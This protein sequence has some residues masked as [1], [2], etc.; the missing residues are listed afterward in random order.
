M[1]LLSNVLALIHLG[2]SQSVIFVEDLG[3][4]ALALFT[5]EHYKT[6][7]KQIEIH[8]HCTDDTFPSIYQ[9]Q[10]SH[11]QPAVPVSWISEEFKDAADKN[12][13]FD[14]CLGIGCCQC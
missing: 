5:R 14:Y 6:S 11:Q 8:T 9:T 13:L 3:G 1:S 2:V 10:S 7:N 4:D 12:C